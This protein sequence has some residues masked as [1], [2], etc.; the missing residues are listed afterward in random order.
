MAEPAKT[1]NPEVAI[2]DEDTFEEFNNDE[3]TAVDPAEAENAPLWEPD[4]DDEEVTDDF[5]S[6][7]R[8]E[9][10]RKMQT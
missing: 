5:Q 2:E 3:W 1:P 6:R 8:E 10:N 9:I 4:W 7:L